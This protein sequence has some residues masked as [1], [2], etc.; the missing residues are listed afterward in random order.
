[1]MAKTAERVVSVVIPTM[2]RPAMLRSAVASVLAQELPEGYGL[3]IL[4]AVSDPGNADDVAVARELAADPAVTPVF[5]DARGAGA[6]RNAAIR[7]SHGEFIAFTDDDCEAQPGWLRA[8][9]EAMTNADLVQGKT[10]PGAPV[11]GREH[12]IWAIPPTW[13]WETCNL[14]VRREFVDRAGPFDESWNASGQVGNQ[15]GEDVEWGW[16]V[17]RLGAR[18]AFVPEALVHHA[19]YPRSYRGYLAYRGRIH[20]FPRLLRTTP[21]IRRKFYLGYFCDRRHAVITAALGLGLGGLAARLAGRRHLGG[22]LVGAGLATYLWP[23]ARPASQ[24]NWLQ[25]LRWMKYMPLQELVEY[26]AAAYGSV[27]WRRLLL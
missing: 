13:L 14:I 18:P 27:R 20:I 25:L 17:V 11:A 7:Q 21:E 9:L 12:T 10:W 8:G 6:A 24:G 2:R 19:V 5:A 16:R 4:V 26:G 23:V 15:Y 1:M 22:V 3:E